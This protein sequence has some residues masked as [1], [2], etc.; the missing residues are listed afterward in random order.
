VGAGGVELGGAGGVTAGTTGEAGMGGMAEPVDCSA[1]GGNAVDFDGH[2]YLF[3]EGE[4]TW[5][6]AVED[7]EGRGAHLVTISSEGR[8]RAGFDAE[9]AFVWQLGGMTPV[10]IGATDGKEPL[11]PGDGT[12]FTWIT[13]EPMTFDAWS[14]GQPNNAQTSCSENT[15]CSCEDGACYEHCGFQWATAGVDPTTVPGWNDRLCEHRIAHVCEWE[16]E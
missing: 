10:W 2:C 16:M 6:E 8:T 7:C 9:N 14:G 4:R 15:S 3:R 12:F 5:D 11:E 13:G 1:H